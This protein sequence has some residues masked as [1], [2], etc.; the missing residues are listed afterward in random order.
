MSERG[1]WLHVKASGLD[2]L[3]ATSDLREV[4]TATP[5]AL[6][7]GRPKGIQG[8]VSYQGE[9]LPVLAWEDLPGGRAAD[10]EPIAMAVLRPRL[11]LPIQRIIG[12]LDP[13]AEAWREV[14]GE[15][16]AAPWLSG[17]CVLEEQ[18]LRALDPVR[19]IALLRR[20]RVDR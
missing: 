12:T 6:L 7:P 18:H 4:V 13:P 8:V 19:L 2:L 15:D 9:F 17:V 14:D 10:G 1:A 3:L 11:G 20:I 16:P 5:V